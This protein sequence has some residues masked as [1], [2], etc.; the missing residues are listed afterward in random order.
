M[1]KLQKIKAL[2]SLYLIAAIDNFGYAI[3][4]ILFS[5]IVLDPKFRLFAA[6]IPHFYQV[7][8]IGLLIGAFPL[9]QFFGSPILGDLADAYGRKKIFLFSLAGTAFSYFLTGWFLLTHNLGLIF[10]GRLLTGLFSAN[11]S[12]CNASIADISTSEKNRARNYGFLT[13]VWGVSFPLALLVSGF[14]SNP[15]LSRF[16]SPS[17]PFYVTGFV[18]L[19]GWIV[20]YY[21]LPETY[22]S[23]KTS[24][25]IHLIQGFG[26]LIQA[27]KARYVRTFF[28]VLFLWNLGWGYS[29]V[30]YPTYA[31]TRFQVDQNFMTLGLIIQGLGWTFGGALLKPALLQKKNTSFIAKTSFLTAAI[32]LLLSYLATSFSV[33]IGIYT[34]AAAFAAMSLSS[35][36]NLISLAS[37]KNIQG[38][39][40]GIAQSV[41]ALGFLFVP[42]FS[43]FFGLFEIYAFFPIAALFLF[44]GSFVLFQTKGLY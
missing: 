33:F 15:S 12:L 1:K 19:F 44:L 25:K 16:F 38:K 27:A 10:L 7:L 30:W 28:L 34:V 20:A 24:L 9:G 11:Q 17:L 35:T 3:A 5:V 8:A 36:F 43:S 21:Y 41:M 31:L 2:F 37:P 32:L 40:M 13:V 29:I 14:L 42:I 6:D 39:S 23:K 22:E 18:S 26:N 4:F